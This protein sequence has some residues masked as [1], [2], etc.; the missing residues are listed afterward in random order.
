MVAAALAAG[1]VMRRIRQPAILGEI[2]AG[3]FIGPTI[4]GAVFPETQLLLF[5]K[6]GDPAVAREAVVKLGL[7]FFLFAAGMEINLTAISRHRKAISLASMLGMLVPFLAGVLMVVC[8]PELWK[9][10]AGGHSFI[11]ALFMG[12]ALCITALP[13]I[14]RILLDYGLLKSELGMTIV[15]AATINDIV[16][17]GL[18]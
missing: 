11:F 16:G 8:L 17:W 3:I 2:L 12:T 1:A 15:A 13:V 14:V 18:F 5:P 10:Q 4:F 9:G 7:L 6:S